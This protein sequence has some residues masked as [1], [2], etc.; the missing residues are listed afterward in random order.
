MVRC[1]SDRDDSRLNPQGHGVCYEDGPRAGCRPQQQHPAQLTLL[2]QLSSVGPGQA[3]RGLP[4][5]QQAD[6]LFR[7]SFD[8][9]EVANL[10]GRTLDLD[11]GFIG[12]EVTTELA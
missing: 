3:G 12:D 4:A 1:S 9:K 7:W 11:S 10:G 6:Y 8:G 5:H 2:I